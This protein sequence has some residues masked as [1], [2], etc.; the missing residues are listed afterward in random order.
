MDDIL[1]S[2][3]KILIYDG[4]KGTM[5]Q[6]AG[7]KN[8]CAEECN[9]SKS[10]EVLK[11]M[12][13]YV[14][15]GADIIQ[16]NTFNANS[17]GLAKH[18][19]KHNLKAYIRKGIELAKRAAVG[20]NIKVAFS[21]GPTGLLM[22]PSG[23]M[24]F[25]KASEIFCEIVKIADKAGADI[26]NFETFTDLYEMKAALL[27]A[28]NVSNLP[29]MC[30][31][32]FEENG[33]TMMGDTPEECAEL[34]T[35]LGAAAVGA[36]CS[37]GA[38]KMQEI[39]E[40]MR[41]ATP[42]PIVAKPNAGLPQNRDG[43]M[44]YIQTPEEFSHECKILA[45]AGATI[46]GGCCGTTPDFI[47]ALAEEL[48]DVQPYKLPKN[49]AYKELE[50]DGLEVAGIIPVKWDED[51][52]LD[53]AFECLEDKPDG[54]CIYDDGYGKLD[55]AAAIFTRTVKVPVYLA[56]PNAEL[57]ERALKTC[58][59]NPGLWI[60]DGEEELEIV[61]S[62]ILQKLCKKYGCKVITT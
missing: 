56:T 29:V 32:A 31:L 6:L 53:M 11:I 46:I 45:Q 26:I 16:T 34:L 42:L 21:A 13:A 20:K 2:E 30:C 14:E 57:L 52:L 37:F 22:E 36:N 19:V 5:L 62:D 60:P 27:A 40:K 61:A 4:S 17:E 59:G 41:G 38:D 55:L 9:L 10:D 28:K 18:N 49:F 51:T 8:G 44:V 43:E 50:M 15:A 25:D 1:Y 24:T 35:R 7:L 23:D 39:I 33:R 58:P 47:K 48:K 3:G 54:I 12:T